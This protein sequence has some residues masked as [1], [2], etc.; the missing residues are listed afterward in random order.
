MKGNE[1][2]RKNLQTRTN[3]PKTCIYQQATNVDIKESNFFFMGAFAKNV[4]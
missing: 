3:E 2:N 4:I 1:I